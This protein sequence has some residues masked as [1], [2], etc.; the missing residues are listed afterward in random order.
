MSKLICY[1]RNPN[2]DNKKIET[3][4]TDSRDAEQHDLIQ[5]RILTGHLRL[6]GRDGHEITFSCS[7]HPA[8]FS[9]SHY[10]IF[11]AASTD[12]V[13]QIDRYCPAE[14]YTCK[15]Y[16][17]TKTHSEVVAVANTLPPSTV[18]DLGCGSGR[19][20]LYLHQLGWDVTA[21]DQALP[22]INNLKSLVHEEGLSHFRADCYDINDATLTGRY[23]WIL[24]TVVMMFLSPD[25]ISDIIQNMQDCTNV[26]GYNLIV[27]A[28]STEDAPCPLPFSFTF[29]KDELARYYRHWKLIKYNENW[30]EL[31]KKNANGDR[32][33]LRFATLFAQKLS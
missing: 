24:S 8:F 17:M 26:G 25:R 5:L 21:L 18:L 33:K 19:N 3:F 22:A 9:K 23:D 2:W 29:G 27:C 32:I 11:V 16:G 20:A 31:H 12:F 1:Q 15:K 7:E 28:M 10:P 6:R 14:E 30:G 13:C 4:F